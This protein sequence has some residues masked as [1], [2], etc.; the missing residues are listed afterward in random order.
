[1]KLIRIPNKLRKDKWLGVS[2]YTYTDDGT[3]RLLSVCSWG[4]RAEHVPHINI[5]GRIIKET[6]L[7]KKFRPESVVRINEEALIWKTRMYIF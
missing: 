7:F 2:I 5:S 3:G 4:D 6:F 1:M